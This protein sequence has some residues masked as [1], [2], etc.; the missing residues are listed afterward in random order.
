MRKQTV[1]LVVCVVGFMGSVIFVSD[2]GL[3]LF[4]A[5]QHIAVNY[6]LILTGALEA[7]VIAWCWGWSE[8]EARTG[9]WYAFCQML[10]LWRI[11]N[12]SQVVPSVT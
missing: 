5:V 7:Y 6:A 9:K 2:L 1:A 3:W 12:I 8:I 4:D 10:E 11:D